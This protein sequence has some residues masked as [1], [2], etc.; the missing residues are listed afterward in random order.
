MNQ[1]EKKEIVD[2]IISVLSTKKADVQE[3]PKKKNTV[4]EHNKSDVPEI[5]KQMTKTESIKRFGFMTN[6][7]KEMP[8]RTTGIKQFFE[9]Y[10]IQLKNKYEKQALTY[11]NKHTILEKQLNGEKPQK[12]NKVK[13]NCIRFLQHKLKNIP[14]ITRYGKEMTDRQRDNIKRA[15]QGEIDRWNK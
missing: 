9:D 3:K 8:Y 2:L 5:L 6:N 1:K 15:I 12:I 10:N 13:Q 4:K 14:E 7:P 11:E